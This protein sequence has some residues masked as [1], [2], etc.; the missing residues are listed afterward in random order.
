MAHGRFEPFG[1]VQTLADRQHDVTLLT[2]YPKWRVKKF[3]ISS[4]RIKS[5][6]WHGAL[7]RLFAWLN[8]KVGFPFPE[9]WLHQMFGSWAARETIKEKWDVIHT[10]SGISEEILKDQ[11]NRSAFKV[12]VR[13]SSHIHTQARILEEEKKRTETLIDKPSHWMI[14]REEREY[15]LADKIRVFSTFAYESFISEE[16]SKE[17]LCLIAPALPVDSFRPQEEIVRRRQKRI[18]SG[19]P[20]QI[21]YVG[22]I[23]YRKG[24]HDLASII[25]A[26]DLNRFCFRLVGPLTPEVKRSSDWTSVCKRAEIIAKK[27]QCELPKIYSWGDLFIFPTLEDGFPQVLA[28]ARANGLPILTTTNGSGPD[29]IQEGRTGWVFPIRSPGAFIERLK[30]CDTERQKLAGMVLEIYNKFHRRDWQETAREF[31][32]TCLENLKKDK[33]GNE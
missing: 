2:N 22:A 13:A 27:P 11:K 17:K 3:G 12:L 7:T 21:L 5:F 18:L 1:L 31:E 8:Q 15:Q 6:W 33:F 19:S 28:Q 32:K 4:V 29:L 16:V 26:I 14:E 30:W 24:F 10:Y 25:Q 20:L 9:S 23:S